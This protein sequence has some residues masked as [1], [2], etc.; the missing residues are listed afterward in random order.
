MR[1]FLGILVAIAVPLASFVT[2]VRSSDP[3]WLW[4]RP[5]LL[6]R[7]L[8]AILVMVPIAEVVLA[9][10]LL[11]E[12]PIIRSGIVISILSIGVGPP[13]MMRRSSGKRE[14]MRY[15]I[16]LNVSLML[17]AVF[18]LPLAVAIHGS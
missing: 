16:G 15:E 10:A 1:P 6:A 9:E 4:K 11:R 2:G 17:A 14:Y 7:S 12:S 5:R 13:Q 18:Y 3:L 8:L